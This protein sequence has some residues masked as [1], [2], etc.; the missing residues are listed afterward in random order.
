MIVMPGC[1]YGFECGRLFG[2]FQGKLGHLQNGDSGKVPRRSTYWA[3]DNGIYGAFLSG[4][5]WDETPFY[6][7][8]EKFAIY[9]P[10]WVAVPDAVADRELTLE[11]WGQH[12]ETVASFGVPL[13]FV[14]QDGM[15]IADVPV[16]AEVVFVGGSTTFKWRTLKTW[17]ENFPRVHVGRVNTYRH[18]WQCHDAGAESCDGTGWFKGGPERLAGLI[19]YLEESTAGGRP[20]VEL[21][22]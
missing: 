17:T 11:R 15:T 22:I 10:E 19:Q 1:D 4:K 2:S 7:Y 8:L 21:C 5:E 20:Q 16:A 14:A 6:D 3:L 12:S 18:L 9:K 13:A